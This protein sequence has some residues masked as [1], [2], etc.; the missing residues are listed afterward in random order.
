MPR[1]P[2]SNIGRVCGPCAEERL[3]PGKFAGQDPAT[4]IGRYVKL[5]FPARFPDT[6][7]DTTEHMWVLVEGR[8]EG[9]ED[10]EL[11]GTL[12]NDPILICAYQSGSLVAFKVVEIEELGPAV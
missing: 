9:K 8:Y 3:K 6:G 10:E 11:I 1:E 2:I 4:F 5:G 7:K 12:N